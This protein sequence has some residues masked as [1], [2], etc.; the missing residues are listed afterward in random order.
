MSK[1]CPKCNHYPADPGNPQIVI[2]PAHFPAC[3][4]FADEDHEHA[5]L[6]EEERRY[7]PTEEPTDEDKRVAALALADTNE[8]VRIAAARQGLVPSTFI[9]LSTNGNDAMM[10]GECRRIGFKA[11]GRLQPLRLSVEPDHA[12]LFSVKPDDLEQIV[13]DGKAWSVLVTN[14]SDKPSP[15]FCFLDALPLDDQPQTPD[16]ASPLAIEIE[17]EILSSRGWVPF[18][19]KAEPR[20]EM[21]P[22][23]PPSD[24]SEPPPTPKE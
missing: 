20:T 16:G 14:I 1:A 17:Q 13:P 24:H 22:W 12:A 18:N 19:H 7:L 15:F 21:T 23:A 6:T 11:N 9:P 4:L 10:P 5:G 3:S 2:G 8:Q